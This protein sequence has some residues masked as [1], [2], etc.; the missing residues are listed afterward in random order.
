V[1]KKTAEAGF[2]TEAD[3]I[4]IAVTMAI[5]V[6]AIVVDVDEDIDVILLGNTFIRIRFKG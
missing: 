3:R 2:G 4:D 5:I 6:R 1:Y